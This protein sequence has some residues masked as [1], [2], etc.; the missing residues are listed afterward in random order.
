MWKSAG[1]STGIPSKM[2]IRILLILVSK[3]RASRATAR[4]A[5]LAPVGRRVAREPQE[6]RIAHRRDHPREAVRAD[7]RSAWRDRRETILHRR[8]HALGHL[9]GGQFLVT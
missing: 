6:R 9:G 8:R 7:W 5:R 1:F 4:V 2:I 3:A